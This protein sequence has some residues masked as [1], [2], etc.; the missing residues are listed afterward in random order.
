MV[1]VLLG[2]E[3]VKL[4]NVPF[5]NNEVELFSVA[6]IGNL[7]LCNVSFTGNVITD[8]PLLTWA[9]ALVVANDAVITTPRIATSDKIWSLFTF[10][11]I[12]DVITAV[13]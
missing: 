13:N 12:F 8:V 4:F 7:K 11:F 10:G 6:F 9:N 3:D 2:A 1:L 5:A